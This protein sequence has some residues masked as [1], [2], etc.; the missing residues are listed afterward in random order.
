MNSSNNLIWE[1][2]K[3]TF[4]LSEQ[5]YVAL[6]GSLYYSNKVNLMN[7]KYFLHKH[8]Q[9]YLM[10]TYRSIDIDNIDDWNTAE[11]IMK[12]LNS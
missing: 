7:F 4:T 8:T 1:K 10:P 11:L 12:G 5:K 2:N 3:K 6:N 9:A